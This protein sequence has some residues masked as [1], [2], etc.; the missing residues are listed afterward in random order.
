MGNVK[1]FDHRVAGTVARAAMICLALCI[2][3]PAAQRATDPLDQYNVVWT[4]PSKDSSGSMPIGNGDIGLNLWVEEDGDLL[5]YISKTDSWSENA[6][7]LKLGRVRIR[8][9]PNPF[10]KGAKFEQTLRLRTGEIVIRAGEEARAVVLRLWVDANRPVIRA[11]ADSRS[12]FGVEVALES[13]RL[14]RRQLEPHELHSAYG[15][16]ESPHPVFVEPDVVVGAQQ[17]RIVWYHRNE[18]SIWAE[19]LRLQ[20]LGDLVG[21]MK[22]PL[23]HR[24]FGAAIKG[25]GLLRV[26]DSA[27]RSAKPATRFQI[28]IYPLTRQTDTAEQ[29]LKQLDGQIADIER[30]DEAQTRVAHHRWWSEFWDRSWIRISGGKDARAVSRGYALQRFINACGGRGAFPIKFNGSIF[31]VDGRRK[32]DRT[33]TEYDAD[34]RSWGGP[35]WWQN[36]RLPYWPMLSCG[37]FDLMQPLFRMYLDALPIAKA[38]T[39]I[40]YNHGGGFYPETIYFWG[41]WVNDNYGWNREG[42]PH[43][44]SDNRYIRREWQGG[45]ELTALMLD[46]Y[47]Y[48]QDKEFLKTALL[49]MAETI[50]AFYD[51][52]YKRDDSRRIRFEPAQALET[53]WDCVNPMPEIAG[54]KSILGKLLSLPEN[55][56]SENQRNKWQRLLDELPPLPTREV[57]GE[58]ILSPA[59]TYA[60]RRN[61]E[62]PELYAVFPYRLYGVGKPDLDM[63]CRTFAHR[64]FKGNNGWRQDDTQAALLGLTDQARQY[65]AGRAVNKHKESRFPAFWGP[66]FDWIPDQDHGGNLLMALQTMLMQT[67]DKKIILLPAWPKQWNVEFKLHA[68]YNTTVEG[69][70]RAGELVSL[71]VTPQSRAKN[72]V[73]TNQE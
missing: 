11:E 4:S 42:K 6:R 68:P 63:A 39:R 23:L 61:S 49:P 14:Q 31:T 29:W 9:I 40:Y 33:V 20:A 12:P 25:H 27:L 47:A 50:T 53:W 3:A 70:Y 13:W 24:T 64:L 16:V 35:Y 26:S 8:L 58:T 65:V 10:V 55:A 19:N 1:V 34:Y 41:T 71:K 43:G 45:I 60:T 30:L 44:L 67:E 54:L 73:R 17:N 18:R 32:V 37:D 28:D 46:H 62:N 15:L 22:D 36:T 59:Q 52:H 57:D 48:T 69:V 51:Q 66:N 56:I 21:T 5:F 72:I 7:L 38:R 2:C